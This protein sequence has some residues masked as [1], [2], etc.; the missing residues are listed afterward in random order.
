MLGFKSFICCLFLWFSIVAPLDFNGVTSRV[1]RQTEITISSNET[2]YEALIV[3][4][5]L[6]TNRASWS[7]KTFKIA[8]NYLK[9]GLKFPN[10]ETYDY[11]LLY[12]EICNTIP[13]SLTSRTI[14]FP[15]HFFT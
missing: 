3:D 12:L 2:D 6:E 14:I 4:Y 10:P 7:L 11:K 1:D 13:L 15:F 9:D 8:Y 5:H